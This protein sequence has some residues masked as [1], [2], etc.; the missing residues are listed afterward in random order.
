MLPWYKFVPLMLQW[1]VIHYITWKC[2]GRALES[3][4]CRWWISVAGICMMRQFLVLYIRSRWPKRKLV[5][6]WKP[7]RWWCSCAVGLEE[8]ER[9]TGRVTFSLYCLHET[10]EIL[11]TFMPTIST[12]SIVS[13]VF[14][15]RSANANFC[16]ALSALCALSRASCIS[17]VLYPVYHKVHL[18]LKVHKVQI[19]HNHFFH[20]SPT[21]LSTPPRPWRWSKEY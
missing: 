11:E 15:C 8:S 19:V 20:N 10:V 16:H 4:W 6:D 1:V 17:W 5:L 21:P 14:W 12:V 7:Q 3:I 18:R 13:N 9:D 2:L